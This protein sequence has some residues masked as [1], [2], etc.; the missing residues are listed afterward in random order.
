MS[1]KKRTFDTLNAEDWA[2]EL[3]GRWLSHVDNFESMLE[4][5]G[6]A[7]LQQA[8]FLP[9][10]RVVD[11]GCGGGA[12]SIAIARQVAPQ[13]T[14]VGIDISPDLVREATRRAQKVALT[15]V[16]FIAAD[17]ATVQLDGARFD[18]LH[19]RF[20]SMFFT[21]PAAAFRNLAS[22]VRP[23]GQAHFAVWAPAKDSPWISGA[24]GILLNHMDLPRPEPR[25]PGPFALDEPD[26]FG[27]L[28]RE[29]GFAD[30][31]FTLWSGEQPIGGAG[32]TASAAVEFVLH[33]M[34]IGDPVLEQP[35]DV[36]QQIRSELHDLFL[37]HERP[38]G[39]MMGAIAWLVSAR[40]N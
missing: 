29:A 37:A 7:L 2:G 8:S 25:A 38:G 40:R 3:G 5:I 17:A 16:R 13:G 30:I 24:M 6:V 31:R 18:G 27:G 10:Q 36:Q 9:G 11:V 28:L 21:G 1:D 35:P 32:S 33:A 4:P 20:G 39:V 23:G 22:L 15:N 34:S 14:V 12:S 19:S 26:Y